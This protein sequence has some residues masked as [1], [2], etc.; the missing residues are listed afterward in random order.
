MVKQCCLSCGM[1]TDPGETKCKWCGAQ[2]PFR[3]RITGETM[4]RGGVDSRQNFPVWER[5]TEALGISSVNLISIRLDV[6]RQSVYDWQKGKTPAIESLI[7]ISEVS[8]ASIHW[9]ITGEGP[10]RVSESPKSPAGPATIYLGEA[11][12]ILITRLATAAG[13]SK[14]EQIR[15]LILENLSQRG[16]IK[17]AVEHADIQNG[18]L[19]GQNLVQARLWG[20]IAAGKPIDMDEE[21]K[22][23]YVARDLVQYGHQTF[24]LEVQGDS[25]IEEDI[26]DG[27]YIICHK[28]N[29]AENGQTVVAL[30]NG[31]AAT[32]KKYFPEYGKVRLQP[33]NRLHE[34]IILHADEVQIQGIVTGIQRRR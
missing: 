17:T 33:A 27:D 31:Y 1:R 18:Q 11:E 3:R 26:R 25:M 34:P 10:H 8:R 2:I 23:V 5:I 16:L 30:I 22:T 7:R 4:A 20:K 14:E 19:Q 13:I 28:S 21:N 29:T 12:H 6:A 15:D 9:L 32:L 24:V